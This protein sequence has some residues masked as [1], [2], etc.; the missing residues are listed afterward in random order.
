[1]SEIQ[2]TLLTSIA[3]ARAHTMAN[4]MTETNITAANTR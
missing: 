3:Q 2:I 1:M 4:G